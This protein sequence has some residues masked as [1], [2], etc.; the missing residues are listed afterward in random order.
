[1]ADIVTV[2][3]DQLGEAAAPTDEMA[4]VV[5]APGGPLQ[6]L[7]FDKLL[8]KLIAT[9]L[10]KASLADLVADLAHDADAV[11]LVFNDPTA[12]QNGWYRKSGA[13]GAGAWVQFETLSVTARTVAEAAMRRAQLAVPFV[14]WEDLLAAT[15]M[16]GGDRAQVLPSD[17]GTHV[18]PVVGGEVTN[19]GVYAYSTDPAGW[20]RV[21]DLD[22]QLARSWRTVQTYLER[23]QIPMDQRFPG[24]MV[25]VVEDQ[26]LFDL[27]ADNLTN[28]GWKTPSWF[29]PITQG[30]IAQRNNRVG[31]SRDEVA[32]GTRFLQTDV[33]PNVLWEFRYVGSP[34]GPLPSSVAL[35]DDTWVSIPQA[36][37]FVALSIASFEALAS[38]ADANPAVTLRWSIL[39]TQPDTQTISWGGTS[40]KI[41]GSARSYVPKDWA[42]PKSLFVVGNSLSDSTDETTTR[43]SVLVAAALGVPLYSVARYT[44]DWRQVYRAG[45]EPIYLTIADDMLP[46]GGTSASITLINGVAPSNDP[47]INPA[48]FLN[49]GDAGLT[50]GVSMSGTLIDGA[51]TRHVTVSIPNAGS[52]A[53]SIVANA[54]SAALT[55]TGAARFIPD[56]SMHMASSDVILWTANNN[57]YSG[58]ANFYG[59]HTNPQVWVDMAKLVAGAQGNR[60]LILPVI[61]ATDWALG[62]EVYNAMLAANARTESFYPQLYAR[63]ADGRDLIEYLQDHG[64]GSANDNSD[65][66]NGWIPRS[67]RRTGDSLHLNAAGDAVVKAFVLEA[68]ARQTLPDPV[69]QETVFALSASGTLT[70]QVLYETETTTTTDVAVTTV[71]QAAAGVDEAARAD[72]AA[73]TPTYIQNASPVTS[74]AALWFKT[75]PGRA[76]ATLWIKD[77]D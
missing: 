28:T 48:S 58:V 49:T 63:S 25:W 11:A 14:A 31:I 47:G 41:P 57:F 61:P 73:M 2:N 27:P 34:S 67:L 66:A 46:V 54:G 15:G 55:L 30:T 6:K 52:T 72:I 3:P 5:F 53:Y 37:D 45:V 10:C 51:N 71:F 43:W 36:S 12:V 35:T 9:N 24:L 42:K 65:V 62:S 4:A 26:R 44:S 23:A 75:V 38:S 39:G 60:V 69:T 40:I 64:D 50:T 70:Y 13:S 1:M 33:I 29:R 21:A 68:L 22:S 16:I 8:A 17:N 77:A 19:A 7:P 56:V 74:S 20:R 76:I 32:E 18:D 59:D